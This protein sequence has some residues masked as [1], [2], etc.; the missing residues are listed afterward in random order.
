M[1]GEICRNKK[2]VFELINET[3]SRNKKKYQ[4][5]IEH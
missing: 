1:S 5:G 3:T 4:E 2:N